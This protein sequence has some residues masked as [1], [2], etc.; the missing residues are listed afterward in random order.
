MR[1]SVKCGA[2]P[3]VPRHRPDCPQKECPEESIDV[4]RCCKSSYPEGHPE[5]IGISRRINKITGEPVESG[6]GYVSRWNAERQG[7]ETQGKIWDS[8]LH[9][10]V[11]AK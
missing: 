1:K 4:L 9:K 11:G 3:G 7:K 2:V 5:R 8:K 6:P 10:Y